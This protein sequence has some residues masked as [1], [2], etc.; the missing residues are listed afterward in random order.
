MEDKN[1]DHLAHIAEMRHLMEQSTKFFSLSGFSGIL[2]GL[3]ATLGGIAAYWITGGSI[4]LEGN[5]PESPKGLEILR[6]TEVQWLLLDAF[7]VLLLS[8][9]ISMLLSQRK[10]RKNNEPVW[11]HATRKLLSHIM[12]PLMVGGIFTLVLLLEG[13]LTLLVPSLLIFYGLGLVN[14]AKYTLDT[15]WYLGIWE[16]GLGLVAAFIQ[17]SIVFWVLGF[18]VLHIIYGAWMHFKFER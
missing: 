17:G 14:A 5:Y 3:I 7:I 11:T 10:A 16:M 8:L 12:L 6:N 15:V 1:S 4:I 18:G 13:H 9:A 2:V